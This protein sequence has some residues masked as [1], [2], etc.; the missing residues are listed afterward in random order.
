MQSQVLVYNNYKTTE[1]VL[2]YT[3]PARGIGGLG[4]C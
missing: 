1:H 3:G 2:V 4:K